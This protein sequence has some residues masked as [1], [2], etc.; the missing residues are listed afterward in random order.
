M[1]ADTEKQIAAYLADGVGILKVA[2]MLGVGSGTVQGPARSGLIGGT[3][4]SMPAMTVMIN[5][6]T[7]RPVPPSWRA[8]EPAGGADV[9]RGALST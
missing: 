1:P 5:V 9:V 2:K 6:V 7:G 4:W 8:P 3:W